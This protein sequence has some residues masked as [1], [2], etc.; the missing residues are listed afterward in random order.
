[1]PYCS[2][3]RNQLPDGATVCNHCGTVYQKKI[4]SNNTYTA[5]PGKKARKQINW[6]DLLSFRNRSHEFY[7]YDTMDNRIFAG[8]SYIGLLAIIPLLLKRRSP[9]AMF[10]VNQGIM[11]LVLTVLI[12]LFF[13]FID[14]IFF[15][16][17][18]PFDYPTVFGYI[19]IGIEAFGIIQCIMGRAIEVPIF[20][21]IKIFK[22]K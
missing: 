16:N 18:M 20:G 19:F 22:T 13:S 2:N 4:V 6:K 5:T 7:A 17:N 1:M 9:Y 11:N 3:C 10:H 21:K 14:G 12:L 8:L 15:Q